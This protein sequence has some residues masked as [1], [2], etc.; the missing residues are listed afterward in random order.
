MIDQFLERYF[1]PLSSTLETIV[2]YS[3]SAFG[4]E[5]PLVVLV[6]VIAG[7]FFTFWLRF[8]NLRGFR[9]AIDL[10]RMKYPPSSNAAGEV[11][12]FQ[13]LATAVSGTV[14]LG[15]I[16][17]VA[18]AITI[19]GPGAAFWM[20]VA[21]F[22]GMST[23]MA[24][25]MLG[26]KYR[27]VR[28]DGTISGGPMYY[29]RDALAEEGRPR[30][31]RALSWF[32]AACIMFA[33]IGT[34]A[35][36]ANQATAQVINVLGDTGLG[37]F[38]DA[39]RW[40]FGLLMAVVVAAVIIGGIQSIAKATGVIVPIMAGT[41]VL[42]CLIVIGTNLG[43]VPSAIAEIVSGAFSPEG[44]AG[45]MIGALLVGFQ[46]AAFSNAAGLGDAAIAHSAVKTDDPVT[47]G[48]VASLEPFVDTIIICSMTAITIVVTGAWLGADPG[49]VNGVQITSD[50]F[51]SV[52]SWFPLVLA[53][54][55]VLFAFSTMLSYSYYGMKGTGFLFGDS[56][57]AENVFKGVFLVF[58]VV[59]AAVALGPVIVFADSIFFLMGLGNVIGLFLL[60]PLI[61]REFDRYWSS[62]RA[63]EF[64]VVD[65]SERAG[66]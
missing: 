14:G 2:F 38:L 60:A 10:V 24:E 21:G 37:Q 58:T 23:K 18:I 54:A 40:S 28:E 49:R 13:A 47:E 17:G 6:L 31:G 11:S 39:N 51:E 22:L 55:V 5:V 36:Q 25:C 64:V 66:R 12:H 19:G 35:F 9:H 34:N 43:Q 20:V 15:N 57:T 62:Y 63:G 8:L 3:V 44:V 50:A 7:T 65:K 32:F 42:A 30:V 16:A 27:K 33:A 61:R 26:V 59:G 48:F 45:G 56:P 4:A 1:G 29:L 52:V 41:Y 53:A 46:R